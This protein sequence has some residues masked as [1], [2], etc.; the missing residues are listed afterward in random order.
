M[1]V[2]N[3]IIEVLDEV[4]SLNEQLKPLQSK[5][6]EKQATLREINEKLPFMLSL[7][8][9]LAEKIID[10]YSKE[11]LKD[12]EDYRKYCKELSNTTRTYYDSRLSNVFDPFYDN[13]HIF[14]YER[15]EDGMIRFKVSCKKNEGSIS[16]LMTFLDTHYTSWFDIKEYEELSKNQFEE[17]LDKKK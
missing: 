6:Q 2:L 12:L 10:T 17:V 14:D 7:R 13:W 1:N 4:N 3:N 11:E 15:N 5:Y 16:G 8:D 9:F